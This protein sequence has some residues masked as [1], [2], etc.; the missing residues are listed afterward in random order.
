MVWAALETAAAFAASV[1]I[2][3]AVERYFVS[4]LIPLPSWPY[5]A[6]FALFIFC[7]VK[8]LLKLVRWTLR[9]TVLA[10]PPA[11]AGTAA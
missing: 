9:R 2:P 6:S 4:N 5:G 7:L 1:W 8:T 11:G 3:G 10:G